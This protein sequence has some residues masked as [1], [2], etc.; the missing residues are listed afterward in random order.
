MIG[1]KDDERISKF[2]QPCVLAEGSH[3]L[4]LYKP[5]FWHIHRVEVDSASSLCEHESDMASEEVGHNLEL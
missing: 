2:S 1:Q 3:W 4:A 5:P